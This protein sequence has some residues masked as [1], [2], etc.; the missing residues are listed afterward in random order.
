MRNAGQALRNLERAFKNFLT[1]PKHG[2]PKFNKKG[3]KDS[4]YLEGT[5][6]ILKGNYIKLPR[7]GIVKTY[8][9]LPHVWGRKKDSNGNPITKKGDKHLN[10]VNGYILWEAVQLA[11]KRTNQKTI[12]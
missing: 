6:K 9:I 2:F 5:I 12:S 1:I 8:E 7:I 3:K 4:F 11:D 10:I